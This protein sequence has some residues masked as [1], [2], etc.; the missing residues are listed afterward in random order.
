[1][2]AISCRFDPGPGYQNRARFESESYQICSVFLNTHPLT[3]AVFMFDFE[4]L[5]VYKKSKLLNSAVRS[6]IRNSNIDKTTANQLTRASLSICL[7]L[8][9]GSGRFTNPDRKNFYIISRSSVFEVAAILDILKDEQVITFQ[10][11]ST[12]YNDLEEISKMV[13]AMI[14]Q[15]NK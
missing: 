15:L 7:N 1:M 4:K 12:L 14:K 9:E 8:A 11:F 10:D 6:L 2:I 3:Q 5:E 13:F